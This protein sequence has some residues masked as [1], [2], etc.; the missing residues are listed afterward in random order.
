[1]EALPLGNGRIGAMVFGGIKQERI[2]LNE[3][4]LWAGEPTDNY[5]NNSQSYIKQVQKLLLAGNPLKAEQLAVEKL[6]ARPTSFRSYQSLGDLNLEFAHKDSVQDYKRLLDLENG[7]AY[8]KY[9][10]GDVKYEREVFIS[11]VDDILI[12]RITTDIPKNIN[13][14]VSLSRE[15]DARIY[16]VS[17]TQI[18]LDGQIIDIP[19]PDAYDD[20]P[21]GSGPGGE[22][23]KFAVRMEVKQKAGSATEKNGMITIKNADQVTLFLS[24]V[25][26]YNLEIMNYDR[27]INSQKSA[28]ERLALVVDKSYQ[29]IKNQHIKEHQSMFNRVTLD[30]SGEDKSNLPTDER[31]KLIQAGVEDKQLICT[32]FQYGRYLLMS[33]S[34]RPG[35]LPANL[36]GVW[37]EHYWAPWEA[38]FHMN[39]NLQMN[40]W[41]AEL[42]NLSETIVP[43]SDWMYNLSKKGNV[44]SRKLFSE[45]G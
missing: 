27:S 8:I 22:H 25:T 4:S 37:N 35:Q 33:S 1:M 26:D 45:N 23:M 2:Q 31:L 34:R 18:N 44:T 40:Y 17:D 12:F 14:K 11:A 32:Y 19:P 41:P 21:G 10:V 30:L 28:K 6:T 15:K 3:E 9:R 38:D 7:I 42:C 29:M 43:L 5:P 36:Q 24:T 13:V 16:T 20:N 39:I